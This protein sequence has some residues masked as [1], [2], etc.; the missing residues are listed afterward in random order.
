[1][2]WDCF[3]VEKNREF[4]LVSFMEIVAAIVKLMLSF[5][6]TKIRPL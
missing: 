4:G 1:M 5:L 2:C 3:S 6:I